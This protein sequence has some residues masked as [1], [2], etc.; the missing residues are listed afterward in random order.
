[1]K[2]HK[3]RL[4]K[5]ITGF[6]I[7]G[8]ERHVVNLLKRLD[9]DQ[10]D[11]SMG[12]L[13]KQGPFLND[14]E[15]LQIPVEEYR[16]ESFRSRKALQQQ[17]KCA[18]Q[19]RAQNIDIVHTYGLYSNVF[20]IPAAK[21]G[22]AARVIASIRDTL[23]FPVFQS[24][25]HKLICRMA[26]AVL[27][28]ANVIKCRLVTDGYNSEK[29]HVIKNGVDASRFE[30]RDE[31][32][33]LRQEFGLS[34]TVPV[35]VVL[36]RLS[37]IKGIEYFL[38]AAAIV[39]K[40]V[41]NA[42]FLIVGDFKDDP[43]YKATL[44]RMAV[45]LGLGRRVIFTGFR[46]DVPDILSE[47]TISVLPCHTG[48]GLSNSILESMAAGL[49]V[50]ATTVGG[51]PELVDDGRTGLLVPPC[52]AG[53]L[54]K[55]ISILLTDTEIARRYGSAARQRVIKEFSLKEMVRSTEDFYLRFIEHEITV[56]PDAPE[57]QRSLSPTG[58]DNST[59]A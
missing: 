17:L 7:G 34:P 21:L 11:V 9:R 18:R 44:T 58:T 48:E 30:R 55:S 31:I 15:R 10:F 36:S 57:R 20:G 26:D 40:R 37:K 43:A 8:T 3:I 23:E 53:A 33:K 25:I 47:A 29:I 42:R 6:E 12:C 51:N 35:V 38:E 14:I 59:S 39:A 27:V 45:R 5:F 4:F 32:G 56:P 16:I 22:G 41:E 1:M 52:D 46:L 24:V 2:N 13:H 28:N 19:I 49:P 54:A 50:I